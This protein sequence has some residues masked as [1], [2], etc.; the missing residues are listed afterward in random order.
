MA[1]LVRE[2]RSAGDPV[3]GKTIFHRSE[4][5]CTVCHAI[6][7]EGGNMGPDLSAIG[8]GM[9][10]DFIIEKLLFPNRSVKQA[11]VSVV[12]TTKDGKEFQGY[13]LREDDQELVLK[14]VLKN[15]ETRIRSDN[16]KAQT[17]RGSLMPA[18]LANNLSRSEFRDL[19]RFLAGLGAPAP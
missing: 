16:I 11:Y 8:T 7:G 10:V 3:R 13:K 18:G 17:D 19:V 1:T 14:D 4:Q 5:M 12:V 6:G 2:V 15:E 9:P